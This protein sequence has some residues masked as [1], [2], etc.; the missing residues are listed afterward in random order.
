[1]EDLRVVLTGP[2]QIELE[3]GPVP[4]EIGANEL[5]IHTRYSAI[6]PGTELALYTGMHIRFG[7]T[8]E[9]RWS[10]PRDVG[11]AAVGQVGRVGGKITTFSTEDWVY[12]HA[13]HRRYSVVDPSERIVCVLPAGIDLRTAPFAIFATISNTAVQLSPPA[14]GD[15]VAIL[16]L[17]LIG[18]MAGQLYHR[19]GARVIGVDPIET[20][21]DIALHC[22]FDSVIDPQNLD[23]PSE[24]R[25]ATGG[26]GAD[27]VIEATGSPPGVP[28]ALSLA[29]RRGQVV[30]LGSTRGVVQ[31]LDVYS[32]IHHA[33]LTVKG[34]HTS[35]F[36]DFDTPGE[37]YTRYAGLQ[38]M[39]ELIAGD[40]LVVAPLITDVVSPGDVRQAYEDLLNRKE[41]H[42]G[43]L[44]DWE[45]G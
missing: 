2:R 44:I 41:E 43:V 21:R 16:G 30:L 10:Y 38:Q 22:G 19:A 42:L 6:S 15:V 26:Q 9:R 1:M 14:S 20:R 45:R 36:P 39:L 23:L 12:A 37:G 4:G 7:Y 34:A 25:N 13:R 11:Y 32:L 31:E 28:L 27:I 24:V 8:D 17:G 35:V 18:I 5:L 29:R 40:E 33:G 3:R